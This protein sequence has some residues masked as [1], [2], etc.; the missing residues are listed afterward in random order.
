MKGGERYLNAKMFVSWLLV[1]GGL[2]WGIVGVTGSNPLDA[3]GS[4]ARIVELV[5]G[6]AAVYK[7]VMLLGGGKK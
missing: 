4:L 5:V 3:L 7:L 2:V 1:I 6:L